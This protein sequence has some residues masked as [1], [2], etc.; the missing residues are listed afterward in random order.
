MLSHEQTFALDVWFHNF[1]G[2]DFWHIMYYVSC[3]L[4]K[5][6]TLPIVSK[7]KDW[8]LRIFTSYAPFQTIFSSGRLEL[9]TAT[10]AN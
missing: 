9:K 8:Q 2:Y 1:L 6:D 5:I 4:E 10:Y 7:E 3:M